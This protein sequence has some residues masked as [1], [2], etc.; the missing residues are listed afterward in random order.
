MLTVA[1]E[2]SVR[3][4]EKWPLAREKGLKRSGAVEV[5]ALSQTIE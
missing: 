5:G 4:T 2:W 1:G 3:M